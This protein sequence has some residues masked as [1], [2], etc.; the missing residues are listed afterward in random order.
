MSML[1]QN[2]D[3]YQSFNSPLLSVIKELHLK[4]S[5]PGWF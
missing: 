5:V 4:Q 3:D 2:Q 1:H